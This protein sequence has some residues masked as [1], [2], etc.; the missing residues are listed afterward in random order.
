MSFPQNAPSPKV[1][2]IAPDF[3]LRGTAGGK[4]TLSD[5]RGQKHVLLAFFPAAFS[6]VCTAEFCEMNDHW[7][8]LAAPNVEVFPISVDAVDSLK[9]FKRKHGMHATLL[10]DFRRE[11]S[12]AY[13]VLFGDFGIAN[14]AYFLIDTHGVIRWVHIEPHPGTRRDS[15]ELIAE[16]TRLA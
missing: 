5:L 15:S 9:E 4:V 6:E 7:D 14:R 3:T 8:Q 16:I 13:G 12:A 1:G 11:V 2:E 10:S